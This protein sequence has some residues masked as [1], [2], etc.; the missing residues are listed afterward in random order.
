MKDTLSIRLLR[1]LSTAKEQL[2]S[3]AL[4]LIKQYVNSQLLEDGVSFKNK[5]GASD[6]YYTAFG[7]LLS[8]VLEIT[9]DGRQRKVYLNSIQRADL[10]L[11]HYAALMR[12]CLLDELMDKGKLQMALAGVKTRE[13]PT[14]SSYHEVPQGDPHNP[15]SQFIWQGLLEDTGHADNTYEV[16]QM[17][18]YH[19]PGQGYANSPAHDMAYLNAT[20]AA[21]VLLGRSNDWKKNDDVTALQ[22]MQEESGGFKASMTAPI[23]D[24]LST[25]T[26]LFV[27]KQYG[28]KP[29]FD[30]SDFIVSHWLE[31]G[32]FAATL[33]DEAS[34]VEYVFY[35]LL[36][37]G[38]L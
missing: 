15:Y 21:L 10:G 14:L 29:L 3:E 35:G 23:A 17:E 37:L 31:N 6:L 34:D 11:I 2:S 33:L 30:A 9:L 26:A 4:A 19:I 32:G 24:L 28:V 5:V 1:T 18:I 36:A 22:Q 38:S 12:C 25:A 7:W 27:L 13:I 20:T 16:S 8:Y